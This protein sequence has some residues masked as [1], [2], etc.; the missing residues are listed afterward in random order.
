MALDSAVK[1][2][3]KSKNVGS[4]P[5]LPSLFSNFFF[6]P[7]SFSMTSFTSIEANRLF[8]RLIKGLRK[9]FEKNLGKVKNGEEVIFFKPHDRKAFDLSNLDSAVKFSGTSKKSDKLVT[10]SPN[11][12]HCG[13][14]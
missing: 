2:N 13:D 14:Y 7:L 6:K 4:S 11:G 5:S 10:S 12:R 3:G 8:H 1:S 9:K